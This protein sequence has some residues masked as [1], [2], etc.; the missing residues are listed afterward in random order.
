MKIVLTD[1]K[2]VAQ[3]TSILKNLKNFSSDIEIHV[4]ETRMYAQGMDGSHCCL[5][6]LQIFSDW[7]TEYESDGSDR[8]GINC[9]LLSKIFSC[10][11]GNESIELNY[12]HDADNLFITLLPMEG[13]TGIV[14]KFKI[15]L[16][17]LESELL[18][19]PDAEYTA[20]IE[21]VSSEFSELVTQLGIFGNELQVKCE[22]DIRLTG[23]G[24]LGS[25]DAVMKEDDILMYAIEED[26]KLE[27]N[28]SMKYINMMMTFNKLNA[29]VQIHLTADMPMKIQ[30]G[31]DTFMD[32]GDDDVED[33]NYIRFFLAPKIE[34]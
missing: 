19:I 27:L 18:T 22:D 2:K 7:F 10:L 12:A 17:D 32:K 20:D 23:K 24:E 5:F 3:F 25:M 14:K 33:K 29:K 6:E 34:D 28:F 4:D 15:P 1:S 30:Y 26:T 31:L 11:N 8:L 21:M 13:E 16:M 9:L